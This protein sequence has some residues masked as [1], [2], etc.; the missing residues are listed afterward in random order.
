MEISKGACVVLVAAWVICE[1]YAV[2][3]PVR[4]YVE[5]G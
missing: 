2:V 3:L 4:L 1:Q 5:F